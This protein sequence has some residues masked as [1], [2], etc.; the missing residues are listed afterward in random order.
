[1]PE[2]VAVFTV[3]HD[4]KSFSVDP[5]VIVHY[6]GDQKYTVVPALNSPL[7]LQD[8]TMEDFDK[9]ENSYYK[10]K[11]SLTAF[12]GGER[13]GTMTV[14]GSD[15][16]GRDGGC[17]DLSATVSYQG[18][19]EP[20]LATTTKGEIPG[21]SS[22]RRAATVPEISILKSLAVKWFLD[23][24]LDR[25]VVLRG[26][27]Q[28]VSSTRLRPDHG[29][30]LIG[31]FD[32]ISKLA[33]HRLFAIAETDQGRY[34]LTLANLEIQHDIGDGTDKTEREFLDQLDIDN[35]G[36]DEIITIA[37]HYESYE[38]DIWKFYENQA[39]NVWRPHYHGIGGGC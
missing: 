7:P 22:S 39:D 9:L 28:H 17:I 16:Q 18:V 33:I 36:A 11:P 10:P 15:I 27:M 32:V 35:D 23:Y 26:H 20:I 21:H 4:G 14:L 1:M 25:Q 34:H 30:A 13:V 6:G 3:R 12:S 19:K 37:T 31:R 8:W 2:D 29:R 24:G 5:V 38:Y